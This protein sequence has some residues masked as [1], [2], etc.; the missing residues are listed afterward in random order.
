MKQKIFVLLIG[1]FSLWPAKGG[2]FK[3]QSAIHARCMV[4]MQPPLSLN[5]LFL[6]N[7]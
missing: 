6:I 4:A 3:K 5:P 2:H 7:F 1:L